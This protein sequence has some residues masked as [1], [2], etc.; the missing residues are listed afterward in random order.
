MRTPPGFRCLFVLEPCD[1]PYLLLFFLFL[2]LRY[3]FKIHVKEKFVLLAFLFV[4]REFS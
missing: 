4:A 3:A 2:D 1:F